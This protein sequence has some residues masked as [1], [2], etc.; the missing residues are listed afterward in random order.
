MK[1]DVKLEKRKANYFK[2]FP[3]V[4]EKSIKTDFGLFVLLG[5]H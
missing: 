1:M 5:N 3:R 4:S 2:S